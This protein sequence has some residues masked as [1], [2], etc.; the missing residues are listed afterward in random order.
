MPPIT[1]ALSPTAQLQLVALQAPVL[2][3][4]AERD[5]FGGGVDMAARARQVLPNCTAEVVPGARHCMSNA[6]MEAACRR[7]MQF[8]KERCGA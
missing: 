5:I 3:I 6:R 7:T 1:T 4:A 8:F 2:V